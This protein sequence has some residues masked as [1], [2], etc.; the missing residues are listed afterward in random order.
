[1]LVAAATA[2]A[3]HPQIPTKIVRPQRIAVGMRAGDQLYPMT[4]EANTNG[5]VTISILDTR[6]DVGLN[7]PSSRMLIDAHDLRIWTSRVRALYKSFADSSVAVEPRPITL[8]NG[9]YRMEFMPIA[10]QRKERRVAFTVYVCGPGGAT[11]V[12]A[13][14][15]ASD[16]LEL[17]DS[18]ATIAGNGFGRPPTLSHPYYASE[19]SCTAKPDASNGR[20][21]AA[22]VREVGAEFVVDT[23]GVVEPTSI[24][25]LPGTEARAATAA[26]AAIAQWHFQPAEIDGTPVRQLVQMPVAF[27]LAAPHDP[28][29]NHKITLEATNDGWVHFQ[30]ENGYNASTVQ[31]WF[32]PDSVDAWAAR[33]HQLNAL[34]DSLPKNV[35]LQMERDT[36]LGPPNGIQF[37]GGFFRHGKTLD[38]RA[39]LW[40]CAGASNE[41]E[42]G[43]VGDAAPFT[44][45]ARTARARRGAPRDFS[46]DVFDAADVAC[47]AWLT[48]TRVTRRE[49]FRVWRYPT[50]AYPASMRRTNAVAE[51]FAAFIVDTAGRVEPKSV[52]VMPGSDPRAVRA[53]PATLAALRFRP[54]TRGGFK[55]R[56]R[57]MQVIRFEPPPTCVDRDAGPTCQRRYSP[58]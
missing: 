36:K 53:I 7:P 20:P 13:A 26:S 12:P 31:E 42:A 23:A 8:G 44:D 47:T 33:V 6:P 25:F 3:Q 17:L 39:N 11:S 40:S 37:S 30:H 27:G 5:W 32:A 43:P 18:A 54:A 48:W 15:E 51:I 19:V 21:R 16:F 35:E 28:S 9:R 4:V 50:G 24:R 14:P 49:F 46:H 34:A 52:R 29:V 58:D 1:M 56:Q 45:A 55:V 41:G 38:W 2:A 10:S 57:V 22:N